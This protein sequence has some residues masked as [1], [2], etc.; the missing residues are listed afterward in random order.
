MLVE[1]GHY[2]K[3]FTRMQVALE[4]PAMVSVHTVWKI[5]ERKRQRALLVRRSKLDVSPISGF[6]E[7]YHANLNTRRNSKSIFFNCEREGLVLSITK[8]GITFT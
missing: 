8:V 2:L 4:R 7:A 1:G 3:R 5:L 6:R